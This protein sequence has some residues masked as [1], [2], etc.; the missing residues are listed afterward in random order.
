MVT[1]GCRDRKSQCLVSVADDGVGVGD[2][3]NSGG[4]RVGDSQETSTGSDSRGGVTVSG[5][6]G[7]GV[8]S[9]GVSTSSVGGGGEG[10]CGVTVSGVSGSGVGEGS[11]NLGNGGVGNGVIA[12]TGVV[13]PHAGV[14][15]VDSLA[16]GGDGRV[17]V[18]GTDDA[19]G[20]G[21]DGG[22]VKGR[23]IAVRGGG[24]TV[25]GSGVTD[26][27]G[28]DDASVSGSQ[29]GGK[30]NKLEENNE[31]KGFSFFLVSIP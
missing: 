8:S 19:L 11:G 29:Q 15:G 28:A 22:G 14:S 24:V 31:S 21:S 3:G 30:D 1:I 17:A 7:G 6:G 4:S 9:R 25:R 12:D 20:L 5:V 26:S 16:V 27:G 2:V 10:R 13:L 23:G 18:S